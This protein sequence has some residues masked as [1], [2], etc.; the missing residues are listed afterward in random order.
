MSEPYFIEKG[1]QKLISENRKVFKGTESEF[2]EYINEKLPKIIEELLQGIWDELYEYSFDKENDLRKHQKEIN[3][4]INKNYGNGI[5]LLE[6][7][8]EMNCQVS[9]STYDKYIKIFDTYEDQLKL[10]TLISLHVRACQIANEIRVLVS[11]GFADGAM[12]RW[13]TLHEICVTFLFLYDNDTKITEMYQDYHV[14][15]RWKKAKEYQ[16]NCEFLDMDKF[17]KEEMGFIESERKDVLE[18][19]GKEFGQSY[20]WTM[21]IL[22]KGRRNIREMEK[23]VK[24]DHHRAVYTWAS[25]NVHSGVSGIN[26]RLGLREE[27]ENFLLPGANDYGF[28]DPVQY[29]TVSLTTMSETFLNMEDSSMSRIFKEFLYALQNEVVNEFGE[30]EKTMPNNV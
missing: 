20:G 3:E 19:Y 27:Q 21:E 14:I 22:P 6:S 5:W 12:S 29:M 1:I 23:L 25:E 30:Q 7:F 28:L 8:I 24:Q 10:D 18:E 9:I 15:E 11:N 13:R 26:K 4:K 2:D 17:S 16:E